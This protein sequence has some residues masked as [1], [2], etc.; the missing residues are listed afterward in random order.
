MAR[1]MVAVTVAV[2]ML[3][4]CGGSA[5]G[6]TAESAH[7][8]VPADSSPAGCR[9]VYVDNPHF[10][11]SV[12]GAVKVNAKAECNVAVPEQDLSV[13]L[14]VDGE[15]LVETVTKAENKRFLFNQETFVRCKN[16]TERHTFQGAA[17]GTSFEGP[18]SRPYV[19]PRLGQAVELTCGI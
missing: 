10:S 9:I 2:A 19:Q 3:L 12:P 7:A 14:L 11:V 18:S 1:M 4:A 17:L 6:A 5:F 16:S 13:T 8:S 15:P